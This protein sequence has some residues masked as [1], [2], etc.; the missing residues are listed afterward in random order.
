MNA[1]QAVLTCYNGE[2]NFMTPNVIEY[3]ETETLCVELSWGTGIFSDKMFGVTVVTRDGERT[4][5]SS[6]FQTKSEAMAY[7]NSLP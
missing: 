4:D 6:C 5:H 1:E 3:M 2:P 7:I